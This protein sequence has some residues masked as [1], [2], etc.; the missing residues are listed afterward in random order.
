MAV[1][2]LLVDLIAGAAHSTWLGG[3]GYAA[4]C[5]LAVTYARRE[6]LL[7]VVTTP[8]AIFLAALITAELV[9]AGGS[10]MLATA[11]GTILT[12]AATAPWLIGVTVACVA[13]AMVR[14]LP[15]C[16]QDLRTAVA[17]LAAGPVPSPP[18]PSLG[19]GPDPAGRG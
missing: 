7:V 17:G 19:T 15:R 9:T 1:V 8:P 2:F 14:G 3:L 6:A 11:E 5:A 10:T 16:V 12:L 18:V 4:G 13:A